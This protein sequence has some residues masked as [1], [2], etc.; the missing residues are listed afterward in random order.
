MYSAYMGEEVIAYEPQAR[1]RKSGSFVKPHALITFK[2]QDD[3]G[4][5]EHVYD[6]WRRAPD[7]RA[8]RI[9]AVKGQTMMINRPSYLYVA[10]AVSSSENESVAASETVS[11]AGSEL[12]HSSTVRTAE[13]NMTL[14][15]LNLP[16]EVCDTLWQRP[17]AKQ[18]IEAYVRK[19]LEGAPVE[20]EAFKVAASFSV[21][22]RAPR[23]GCWVTF[24][25]AAQGLKV[26]ADDGKP[27]TFDGF[28]KLYDG[29]KD[30]KTIAQMYERSMDA[31]KD[32]ERRL[33]QG[34]RP[35]SVTSWFMR[36]VRDMAV[37]P[38]L[39]ADDHQLTKVWTK[40]QL[41]QNFLYVQF[42]RAS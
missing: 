30:G 10:R 41:K 15:F 26:N 38:P 5:V 1:A 6:L 17:A 4:Y 28:Q 11:R 39:G 19:V 23:N 13:K 35:T 33:G 27:Y 21:P 42:A 24:S 12:S 16:E 36:R 20:T 8:V 29:K 25:Y 32:I 9:V 22:R 18:T 14:L 34:G 7:R 3:V 40:C 37:T 31:A 2:S